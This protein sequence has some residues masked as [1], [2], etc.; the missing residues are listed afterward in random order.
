MR[1]TLRLLTA[2]QFQRATGLI[3]AMEYLRRSQAG[4]LGTSPFTIGI[5]LGGELWPGTGDQ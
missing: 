3:C 2:Q 1:Y 4:V 5:W